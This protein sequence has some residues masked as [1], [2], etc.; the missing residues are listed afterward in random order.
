[1]PVTTVGKVPAYS[2]TVAELYKTTALQPVPVP[3]E[4]EVH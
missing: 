3:E 1:M 4:P 2:G